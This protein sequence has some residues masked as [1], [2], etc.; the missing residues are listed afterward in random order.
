MRLKKKKKINKDKR[1]TFRST[2]KELNKMQVK[3]NLYTDG[4]LSEYILFAALNFV[5]SGDELE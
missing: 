2:E 4:N 5:P 3:A 1:T